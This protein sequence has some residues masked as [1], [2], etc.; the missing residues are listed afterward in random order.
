MY[1][2]CTK[3]RVVSWC[4][5]E[6]LKSCMLR[7]RIIESRK[8][9]VFKGSSFWTSLSDFVWIFREV[10]WDFSCVLKVFSI[11]F[12]RLG[13]AEVT[14][15]IFVQSKWK[16]SCHKCH[17]NGPRVTFVFLKPIFTGLTEMAEICILLR[18]GASADSLQ[19]AEG[20]AGITLI[21]KWL[22]SK[23]YSISVYVG[24]VTGLHLYANISGL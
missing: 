23:L 8:V 6:I 22:C 7:N 9:L 17:I 2:V 18:G 24:C 16:G 10:H 5:S 1:I 11:F 4:S 3:S 21:K 12:C 13:H 14:P 20:A 15:N 19:T